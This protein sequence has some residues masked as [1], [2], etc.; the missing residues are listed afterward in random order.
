MIANMN[1]NVN[2]KITLLKNMITNMND[3]KIW[4]CPRECFRPLPFDNFYSTQSY[5]FG[6]KGLG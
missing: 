5:G 1:E 4:L 6:Y 2:N 3:N